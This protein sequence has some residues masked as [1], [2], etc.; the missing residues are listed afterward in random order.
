MINIKSSLTIEHF[1]V[2]KKHSLILVSNIINFVLTCLA[3]LCFVSVFAEFTLKTL[4][5]KEKIK[6]FFENEILN[7]DN[8]VKAV[9]TK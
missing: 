9:K 2:F 3:M 1:F 5:L 6:I 8:F 7:F 4:F